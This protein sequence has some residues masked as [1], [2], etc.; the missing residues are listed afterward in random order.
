MFPATLP[1]H[2]G[3]NKPEAAAENHLESLE[4]RAWAA[5]LGLK[6][7]PGPHPRLTPGQGHSSPGPPGSPRA[8]PACDSQWRVFETFTYVI[9]LLI[10]LSCFCFS[11]DSAAPGRAETEEGRGRGVFFLAFEVQKLRPSEETKDL[12]ALIACKEPC[13]QSPHPEKDWLGSK[14]QALPRVGGPC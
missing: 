2:R 11:P 13:F 8:Q 6:R 7:Q 3:K 4:P 5:C 14:E 12:Q 10:F 9:C 1:D